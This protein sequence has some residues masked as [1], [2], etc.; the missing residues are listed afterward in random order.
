MINKRHLYSHKKLTLIDL[1][2]RLGRVLIT[3]F[4]PVVL[5]FMGYGLRNSAA[6]GFFIGEM[7]ML[8]EIHHNLLSLFPL[9][10]R[11]LIDGDVEIRKLRCGLH[12]F[13]FHRPMA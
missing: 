11:Q 13:L 2:A 8:H 10:S 3:S 4:I 9:L 1:A 12:P 6:G 5:D 7:E